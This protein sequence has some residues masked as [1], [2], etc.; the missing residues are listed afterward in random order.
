MKKLLLSVTAFLI[1]HAL[2]AQI[3][4]GIIVYERKVNMHLRMADEQMKAMVPEYRTSKYQLMFSDSSSLYKAVAE[5][6]APDPFTPSGGPVM[7]FK[8]DGDDGEQYRN[9]AQAK[10]IE[11]RPLGAKTYIIEDSIKQPAWKL[12]GETKSILNYTCKKA[13]LQNERGQ[14]IE[15]WYTES[16]P[17]PAGPENFTG[18]PGAILQADIN[19]GEIVFTATRIT[20]K[21]EK[22]EI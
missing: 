11:S 17:G 3:R 18:L 4:E 6:N 1:V 13:T 12:T 16:I 8:M 20:P 9:F 19:A 7:I 2:L 5:E 22:K 10:L 14:S 15:A 21:V